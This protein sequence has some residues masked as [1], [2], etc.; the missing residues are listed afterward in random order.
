MMLHARHREAMRTSTSITRTR[1]RMY[2]PKCV[3]VDPESVIRILNRAKV[4][5]VLVG[6][7]G[8]TGWRSEERA[9][10][11]VDVLIR[12]KDHRKAV[13]AVRKAFPELIMTDHM[14]VT[15]F[16]DPAT[17]KVVL[18]LMKPTERI[19]RAVFRNTVP[20]GRTHRIPDLEMSL[21]VKF[22]AMISPNRPEP[23]KYIDAGDFLDVVLHN[24]DEIDMTK[25]KRF[26]ELVYNGGG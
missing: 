18:D 23:K 19:L 16:A 8:I 3:M 4:A 17:R 21:A 11:D 1:R 12:A 14:V 6:T 7:Y 15:R 26:G 22:A 10:Q 25:L 20:V 5:F 13:D 9:T 24:R 2:W